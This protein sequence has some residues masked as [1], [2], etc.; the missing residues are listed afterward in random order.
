MKTLEQDED[1]CAEQSCDAVILRASSYRQNLCFDPIV[2]S[3]S[4]FGNFRHPPRAGFTCRE[5]SVDWDSFQNEATLLPQSRYLTGKKLA[6]GD[7]DQHPTNFFLLHLARNL[8]SRAARIGHPLPTP[9]GID[10]HHAF[11][12][13]VDSPD[14]FDDQ[15]PS[16]Y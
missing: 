5:I 6:P 7:Q 10:R 3:F 16:G 8:S 15:L 2:L 12:R 11:L 9:S 13:H 14:V 1:E 4:S